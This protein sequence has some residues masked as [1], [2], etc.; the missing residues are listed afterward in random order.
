LSGFIYRSYSVLLR[1]FS[2]NLAAKE[3]KL[4]QGS[5]AV[6]GGDEWMGDNLASTCFGAASILKTRYLLGVRH[7]P[8]EISARLGVA[9]EGLI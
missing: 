8:C 4:K 1:I 5:L 6:M 9:K 3:R 7:R 2:M